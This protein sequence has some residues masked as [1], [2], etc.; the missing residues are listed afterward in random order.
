MTTPTQTPPMPA[1]QSRGAE[2]A[3][4]SFPFDVG[5]VSG[6]FVGAYQSIASDLSE[7][8]GDEDIARADLFEI[9]LDQESWAD[10]WT[11]TRELA[12]AFREWVRAST[13]EQMQAL[14]PFVLIHEIYC[15]R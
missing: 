4:P 2:Y 12:T 14:A 15:L 1:N 5:V 10:D 9:I 13:W 6:W 11:C 3:F 7:A 8:S